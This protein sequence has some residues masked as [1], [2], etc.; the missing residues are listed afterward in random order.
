MAV[1]ILKR[2]NISD[3]A[4]VKRTRPVVVCVHAKIPNAEAGNAKNGTDSTVYHACVAVMCTTPRHTCRRVHHA[5][6]DEVRLAEGCR[7]VID[8]VF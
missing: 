3:S 6:V 7:P 8:L 2:N 5:Y 1:S 4:S